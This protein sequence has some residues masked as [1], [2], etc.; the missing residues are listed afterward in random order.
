MFVGGMRMGLWILATMVAC[1][2]TK[3]PVEDAAVETTEDTAVEDANS[4]DTA[5]V[6]DT[7]TGDTDTTD[8]TDTGTTDTD[9]G[10]TDT[11]TDSCA[12][13]P[14]TDNQMAQDLTGR[15]ECGEPVY[16]S[17]C[18]AYHGA[19]GE[20]ASGPNIQGA[21]SDT[22]GEVQVL[23]VLAFGAGGMPAQNLRPQEAADVVAYIR[24]NL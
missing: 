13:D 24:D 1:A 10:T 16:Q 15:P 18:V 23:W 3:V 21:A 11:N 9:T 6:E 4:T 17:H 5:V 20:G 14:A 8:T 19:N 7:N 12:I 22:W 2:D